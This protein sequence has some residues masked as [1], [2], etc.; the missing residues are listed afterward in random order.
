MSSI[1][2]RMAA[3]GNDARH[4]RS[5]GLAA[6]G[7]ATGTGDEDAAAAEDGEGGACASRL[8]PSRARRSEVAG[9]T[10]TNEKGRRTSGIYH[11]RPTAI[12]VRQ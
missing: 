12:A 1:V 6:A 3:T 10:H 9:P 8:Q 5:D 7:G 4:E 2:G 11:G